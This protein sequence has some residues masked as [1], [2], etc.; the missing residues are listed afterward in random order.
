M[1]GGEYYNAMVDAVRSHG[2]YFKATQLDGSSFADPKFQ[3]AIGETAAAV[4][5]E[6]KLCRRGLLHF[7]DVPAE[8]LVGGW[9]PCRLF[10]VA[11]SAIIAGEAHKYGAKSLTVVR[12]LPSW[13]ALGPNGRV[14]AQFI[15]ED[16]T[17]G[18]AARHAARRAAGSAAGSAARY[19][20]WHAA[21]RAAG[22]AARAR[23]AAWGA[24]RAL[25][26]ADLIAPEQFATLYA[27]FSTV[28]PLEELRKRAVAAFPL[29]VQP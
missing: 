29:T 15:Q 3:Y 1:T 26:V 16:A 19:A 18:Y 12:E 14:V 10:E 21:R 2:N 23:D 4:G 22:S 25:V 5:D 7:S 17:L 20:A 24:G 6:S 8:T 11:P 13:L 28:L 27:P 9:W